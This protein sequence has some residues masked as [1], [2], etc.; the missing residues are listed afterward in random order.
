MM[1][2]GWA[3]MGDKRAFGREIRIKIKI[4]IKSGSKSIITNMGR[5]G[6]LTP[7]KYRT[8]RMALRFTAPD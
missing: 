2:I 1:E 8:E 5:I 6:S 7:G 3:K 4:K